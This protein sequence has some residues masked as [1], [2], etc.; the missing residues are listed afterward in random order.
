MGCPRR[1]PGRRRGR[2][3]DGAGPRRSPRRTRRPAPPAGTPRADR[4]SRPHG[5]WPGGP[6]CSPRRPAG[7]RSTP[8]GRR[9]R[10]VPPGPSDR[11]ADRPPA[12]SGTAPRRRP[13]HRRAARCP[14][15][16]RP[17]ACSRPARGGLP[18][19]TAV[20]W[21][22]RSTPR[23]TH[24]AA[25]RGGS[26]PGSPGGR[27]HGPA[28]RSKRLRWPERSHRRAVRGTSAAGSAAA[29]RHRS[30]TA[31]PAR[32]GPPVVRRVGSAPA[33]PT[34][35][36]ERLRAPGRTV[37]PARSRPHHGRG[38]PRRGRR[39]PGAARPPG[40]QWWAPARWQDRAP[41]ARARAQRRSAT[42]A[43]PPRPPRPR[44]RPR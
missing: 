37:G 11:L 16:A 27:D 6:S 4:G 31:P 2:L 33:H 44:R 23:R 22:W 25:A 18:G 43:R 32:P 28:I 7:R 42:V 41:S 30:G 3:P 1:R 13:V 19:A 8:A 21:R 35:C 29:H 34:R 15:H 40:R 38:T 24:P 14:T 12:R 39:P 26:R 9:S 17:P 36:G 10:A 5:R 20:R